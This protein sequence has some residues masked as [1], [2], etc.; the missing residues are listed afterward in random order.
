MQL[1]VGARSSPVALL[2]GHHVR[3]AYDW[4]RLS[5]AVRDARTAMEL[6]Q[7]AL[8]ARAS[9]GMN[10]INNLEGGRRYTRLPNKINQI[11]RALGWAPGSAEAI[12]RGGEPTLLSVSGRSAESVQPPATGG[13]PAGDSALPVSVRRALENGETFA[14]DVI[15]IRGLNL[16]VIAK[17]GAYTTE[18][19]EAAIAGQAKDWDMVRELIRDAARQHDRPSD[20]TTNE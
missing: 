4:E 13:I 2:V 8:A 15:N 11:E 3:V 9:V 1:M 7:G 17:A 18:D 12:L 10:T 5:T 19:I 20:E 16:I 14:A 6:S